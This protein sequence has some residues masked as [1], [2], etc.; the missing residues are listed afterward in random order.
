MYDTAHSSGRMS[1]RL[2]GPHEIRMARKYGAVRPRRGGPAVT[3]RAITPEVVRGRSD[4]APLLGL[5]VVL[6]DNYRAA[7]GRRRKGKTVL[8]AYWDEKLREGT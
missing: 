4:L 6:A 3:V 7:K 8:T 1:D 2:I 5:T